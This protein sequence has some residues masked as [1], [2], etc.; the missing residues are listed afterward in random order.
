M[1]KKKQPYV[2][3]QIVKDKDKNDSE[4]VR[5]PVDELRKYLNKAKKQ[6]AEGIE[7]HF[8]SSSSKKPLAVQFSTSEIKRA[9]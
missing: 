5:V 3:F 4:T 7:F 1:I 6:G 9:L 2:D 8:K